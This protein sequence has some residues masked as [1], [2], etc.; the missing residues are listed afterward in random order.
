MNISYSLTAR[1]GGGESHRVELGL[2]TKAFSRRF[3][4]I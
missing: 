3:T 2:R 4:S 1:S